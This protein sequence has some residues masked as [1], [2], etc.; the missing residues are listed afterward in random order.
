MLQPQHWL[1]CC[2]RCSSVPKEKETLP[3]HSYA[4]RVPCGATHRDDILALSQQGDQASNHD[5]GGEG[6]GLGPV[7]GHHRCQRAQHLA[8]GRKG[9]GCVSVADDTTTL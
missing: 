9:C 5:E 4:S 2:A 1:A 8:G 3:A 6:P 7:V